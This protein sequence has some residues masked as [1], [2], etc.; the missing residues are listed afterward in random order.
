MSLSYFRY[1][2]WCSMIISG[3]CLCQH[4]VLYKKSSAYYR[5]Y[6]FVKFFIK[7]L[8]SCFSPKNTY[9]APYEYNP[10]NR[11][12]RHEIL[13]GI[14]KVPLEFGIVLGAFFVARAIRE[15][16][17][18]IPW[19]ALPPQSIDDPMLW[20]FTLFGALLFVVVFALGGLYHIRVSESRGKE[21]TGIFSYTFYACLVY[22]ACVYLGNGYIYTVQIPRL[23]IFYA[24]IMIVPAVLAERALLNT[25]QKTLLRRGMLEKRRILLF[26]RAYE[27][28]VVEA[29][30]ETDIYTIVGY[31]N[32]V[33]VPGM[34]VPYR[35]VGDEASALVR[36]G[37]VDEILSV[38]TDFSPEEL[39]EIFEY[40]R[41]YG[42]RYRYITNFFEATRMNTELS[43]VRGLPCI[44]IKSI[45]LQPWGRVLKRTVDIIGSILF[46]ILLSPVFAVIAILIRLED[47]E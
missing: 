39:Q 12:K 25:L 3:S 41:I 35:G 10:P 29:I 7:N 36:Q 1:L 17:D 13:F 45:G 2:P 23:I 32:A 43:F 24:F 34:S 5:I 30:E 37:E 46:L 18:L 38:H 42:V 22:I 33:P 47:P 11:M 40:A 8:F 28:E 14:A 20:V 9:P 21:A 31:A 6:N 15:A 26:M 44:E 4:K 19:I 16:T 27:P